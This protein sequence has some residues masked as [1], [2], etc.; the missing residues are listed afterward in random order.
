MIRILTRLKSEPW[1]ITHEAMATI[2][3]IAQRENES[4]EAVAAKI[5]RPLENTYQVE[6]RDGIAILTATGPMFRYATFFTMISGGTSYDL[7]AR[8][9]Q[10][11]LDNPRIHSIVLNIDS[12]GGE[13]SGVS[14]FADQIHAARAKKNI[15]AYVGGGG[16]SAA[17]WLASAASEIV[18]ADT[19]MLGSIGVVLGVEDSRARDERNGVKRLEIVSAASPYKRVDPTSAEGQSRLQARVDALADVFL[20][21]VARNRDTD[22]ETVAREFG[23][24]DVFLGQAAVDAGL[25]DRVGDYESLIAELANRQY[26]APAQR[27]TARKSTASADAPSTETT[28]AADA[29]HDQE[30][31][32]DDNKGAPAADTKPSKL[33]A[34]QVVE[35]QPDAAA[36]LQGTAKAEGTTEGRTAE[37][38]RVSAILGSEEAVGRE[39]MAKHLAFETD[40]TV[41]AA[42]ALLGKAPKAAAATAAPAKANALD[43][44]MRDVGNAN[45]GADADK[46]GDRDE[47]AAILETAKLVGLA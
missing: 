29:L 44:A 35:Q 6:E 10:K 1:A 46:S 37:R 25:A 39:D 41:E 21:K 13:A 47:A 19:A 15:V 18:V 17:Y 30:S 3:E 24:G 9:F 40:T 12:P 28:T 14:E 16:A 27:A 45:V 5:G 26:Q 7:L 43:A 31:T 23:Q 38:A 22:V 4:P 33:T 8:D 36:Q 2:I 42:V 11:A 20:A 34:A 32:M